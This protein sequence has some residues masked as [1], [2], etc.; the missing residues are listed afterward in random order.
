MGT[1]VPHGG[2]LRTEDLYGGLRM[3]AA[4]TRFTPTSHYTTT[5]S[6]AQTMSQVQA[7]ASCVL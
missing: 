4:G 3:S 6:T 2:G 1:P 5:P 7:N